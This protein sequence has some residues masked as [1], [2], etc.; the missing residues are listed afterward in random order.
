MIPSKVEP[1]QPHR[2]NMKVKCSKHSESAFLSLP[3]DV[4]RRIFSI[5]GIL[6]GD[7]PVQ[8]QD[9]DWFVRSQYWSRENAPHDGLSRVMFLDLARVATRQM[10]VGIMHTPDKAT[11]LALMLACRAL[12]NE[13]A[14]IVYSTNRFYLNYQTTGSLQSLRNL[15]RQAWSAL[16]S[17]S[18]HLNETSCGLKPCERAERPWNEA[19]GQGSKQP[20]QLPD[21]KHIIDEWQQLWRDHLE[22]NSTSPG[23]LELNLVCDVAD[24]ETGMAIVQPLLNV[25]KP[26]LAKCRIRLS[27]HKHLEL[28]RL[29]QQ[30]VEA[31]VAPAKRVESSSD[32]SVTKSFPIMDLPVEIRRLILQYTDLVAPH[33]EVEWNARHRCYYRRPALRSVLREEEAPLCGSASWV[34]SVQ[35]NQKNC[36]RPEH[37]SSWTCWNDSWNRGCF[38][39]AYHSAYSSSIFCYCWAPP[40]PLFLVCKAIRQDALQV[41]YSCNHFVIAPDCV[42]FERL[43]VVDVAPERLAPSIFLREVIPQEALRHLRRLDFVFPAFGDTK[44]VAYCAT[45]S[46]CQ[47]DWLS[48]LNSAKDSLTLARL[49]VRVSFGF[50]PHS[51][52]SGWGEYRQAMTQEQRRQYKD[53]YK[54]TVSPL[55]AWRGLARFYVH[56]PDPQMSCW[57]SGELRDAALEQEIEKWVM[58]ADYEAEGK[59]DMAQTL[60]EQWDGVGMW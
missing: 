43:G 11:T 19:K 13:V 23:T 52:P 7:S 4:R 42:D 25:T 20:L 34:E 28:Q 3:A 9:G 45:N 50:H 49:S 59:S 51:H 22:P 39:R 38:C 27:A 37:L 36:W 14:A 16:R 1:L 33:A 60:A 56:L 8:A 10:G 31:L 46:G 6:D 17:L 57:W 12:Y 55:R 30:A 48:A 58:G 44:A 32:G 40:T 54:S 24:T 5:A 26:C 15:G 47:Q 53:C 41:F 2:Q 29:A 35:R 21:C 18:L